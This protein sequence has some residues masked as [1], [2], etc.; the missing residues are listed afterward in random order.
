MQY[1]N[2][3]YLKENVIFKQQYQSEIIE[4]VGLKQGLIVEQ[5]KL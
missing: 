2:H 4:K 5:E 3:R 1:I